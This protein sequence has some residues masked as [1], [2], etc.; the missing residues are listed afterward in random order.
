MASGLV[1]PDGSEVEENHVRVLQCLDCGTLEE[2]PDF[3][4][5]AEYDNLLE[6]LVQRHDNHAGK[7]F[8]VPE[9]SWIRTDTR[10]RIIEQIRG[11]SKGIAEFSDGYYDVA[12][13]FREDALKCYAKHLRPQEGC[14]EF[15]SDKKRLLPDT[16]AERKEAGLPIRPTGPTTY[17]CDFCPCK[18]YYERKA[19]GE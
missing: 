6:M 1:L 5:P 18:S 8:R 13:T 9:S 3:D 19:R 11:G 15:R 10:H 7:L 4:G 16:K 17:L 12:D 14:P 2:L